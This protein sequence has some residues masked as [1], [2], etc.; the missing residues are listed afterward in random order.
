MRVSLIQMDV[1]FGR[2]DA[3]RQKVEELIAEAAEEKPDIVVLPE[4]WNTGFF[5]ENVKELADKNGEPTRSLLAK[6]AQ[7]H[8]VNI[9]GGSVSN[10]IDGK[11]YNTNFVFNRNGEL[12]SSYNKIHLF[13]PADEHEVFERGKEVNVFEIE[14]VKAATVICYD[15]RFV[16]LIR[17]LA[18]QGIEILFV[19][20]QWPHPRLE[21][22]K[23]LIKA[24]SIENQMFVAAVNGSGKSD[25]LEFCGNSMLL[26]PWGKVIVKADEQE[27]IITGEVDLSIIKEIREKINVFR[28][29]RPEVYNI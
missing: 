10:N 21:H 24:R 3:N 7:K 19:P 17:T 16:E 15:I 2:P 25:T 6:L 20:A 13:S 28:D 11:V 8:A 5:P 4:T 18:L 1:V 26:D 23:T 14:G 12:V 27:K 29:R 22:W 9:V